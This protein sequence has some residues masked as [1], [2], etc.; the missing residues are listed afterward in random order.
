[1]KRKRFIIA[2]IDMEREIIAN[3]EL[4]IEKGEN[5]KSGKLKGAWKH[6]Q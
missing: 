2:N 1:M 5:G 4:H 3:S 6:S